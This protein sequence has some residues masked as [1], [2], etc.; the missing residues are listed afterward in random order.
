MLNEIQSA[1][2]L[3]IINFSTGKKTLVNKIAIPFLVPA[4]FAIVVVA[5]AVVF[6]YFRRSDK[7][8]LPISG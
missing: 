2:N 1:L 3:F 8:T 4:F 7:P 5:A 6:W